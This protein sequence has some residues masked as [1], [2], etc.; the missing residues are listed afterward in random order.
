M[1]GDPVPFLPTTFLAPGTVSVTATGSSVVD[2]TQ[3]T[4]IID[5]V[6]VTNSGQGVILPPTMQGITGDPNDS[7]LGSISLT[8]NN[9]GPFSFMLSLMEIP[10]IPF[11]ATFKL[12]RGSRR[13][14]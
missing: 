12:A 13:Q 2:A 6:T 5:N 11:W 9:V 8:V 14:Y 3:L 7:G 10:A 4:N 1:N